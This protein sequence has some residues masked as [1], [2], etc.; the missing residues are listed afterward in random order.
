M[1]RSRVRALTGGGRSANLLDRHI[2]ADD[3]KVDILE[4]A[5]RFYLAKLGQENLSQ[6]QVQMEM[7]RLAIVSDLEDI[8][9][10][11]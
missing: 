1:P 9:D 8:G 4:K 10:T 2:R 6:E 11:I 3:D 7:S 5:V